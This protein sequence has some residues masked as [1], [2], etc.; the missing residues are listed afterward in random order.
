MPDEDPNQQVKKGKTIKFNAQRF[1]THQ[2]G[3]LLEEYAIGDLLGSG[4]FGEV[5]LGKH[6]K[7]GH[8]R[9]IKVVTKSPV[10]ESINAAVLH[11]FN[12]VRKLDHPY[13]QIDA[14]CFYLYC[15][16]H[17]LYSDS[18]LLNVLPNL[19]R[20]RN[21]LKMYNLYQDDSYFYIGKCWGFFLFLLWTSD[22]IND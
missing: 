4:G 6:K 16:R 3:K 18:C 17:C 15:I 8:E 12:V 22:A 21:I 14:M 2:V 1:V 10:D 11:E 19:H 20:H 7:S 13:V 5:Y 9:A